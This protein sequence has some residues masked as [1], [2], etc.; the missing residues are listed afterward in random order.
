MSNLSEEDEKILKNMIEREKTVS[1]MWGWF[2][3]IVVVAAGGLITL[4]TF[5]DLFKD[6]K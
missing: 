6:P 1:R 2:R 4:W 5:F 3:N